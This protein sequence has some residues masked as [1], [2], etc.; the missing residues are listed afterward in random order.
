MMEVVSATNIMVVRIQQQFNYNPLAN[1]DNGTCTYPIYGYTGC[2]M[3]NPNALANTNDGSCIPASIWL[4][5][6]N[7]V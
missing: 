2:T 7:Y 3:F 4:Y 6:P 5:R 1:T